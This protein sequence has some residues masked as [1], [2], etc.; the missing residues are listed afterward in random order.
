MKILIAGS[1]G[2]IG[3]RL[4][5]LLKRENH[6]IISL[7]RKDLSNKN[8]PDFFTAVDIVINCIG[9]DI[10]NSKNYF[11][12]KKINYDIPL[13]LLNISC[14]KKVKYFFFISSFHVYD[15][16]KKKKINELTKLKITN[17]YNKSKILCEKKLQKKKK[18]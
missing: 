4:S 12:T 18:Y 7:N 5:S 14:K 17:N 15:Q 11:Q 16:S 9:V 1:N 13:N 10:N 8:F 3:S 6:K 2:L